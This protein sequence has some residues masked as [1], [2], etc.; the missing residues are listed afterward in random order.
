MQNN[1]DKV[2]LSPFSTM[3]DIVVSDHTLRV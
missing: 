1:T 3:G 2:L